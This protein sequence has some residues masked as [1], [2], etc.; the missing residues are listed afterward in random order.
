MDF[1]FIVVFSQFPPVFFKETN[2]RKTPKGKNK[3]KSVR[4]AAFK[5]HSCK[6]KRKT[7]APFAHQN[8]LIKKFCVFPLVCVT[9]VKTLSNFTF[10][11]SF[12]ASSERNQYLCAHWGHN[13][14]LSTYFPF[15]LVFYQT[16][17]MFLRKHLSNVLKVFYLL[18]TFFF[19]HFCLILSWWKEMEHS[20]FLKTAVFAV[21]NFKGPFYFHFFF[22]SFTSNRRDERFFFV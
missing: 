17:S 19:T 6:R 16:V 20:N 22:S 7:C 8:K 10:L 21:A 3:K 5:K 18:N 9:K 2:F 11:G 13:S 1:V 4:I 12:L 15:T 14:F